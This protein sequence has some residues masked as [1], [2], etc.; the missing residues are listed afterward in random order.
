MSASRA[1]VVLAAL[2]LASSIAACPSREPPASSP[3]SSCSTTSPPTPTTDLAP[4][5]T[6]APP[7]T[8]RA[9]PT[10]S[11]PETPDAGAIGAPPFGPS[12]PF[13]AGGRPMPTRPSPSPEQ[14]TAVPLGARR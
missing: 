7:T 6:A 4:T 10:Q 8:T 5:T 11:I 12:S 13:D 1:V 14:P 3:T 2:A 9:A